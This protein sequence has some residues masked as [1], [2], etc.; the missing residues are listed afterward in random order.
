M[1][2]T[3]DM[4]TAFV[5]AVMN[6]V[7]KKDYDDL[8]RSAAT[9]AAL[10]ALPRA[11]ASIY[12]K[13]DTRQFVRMHHIYL[14]IENP[15][16][17]YIQDLSVAVP[18]GDVTGALIRTACADLLTEAGAQHQTREDLRLSLQVAA[19]RCTTTEELTKVFPEFARYVPKDPALATRNLPALANVVESFKKAGWSA[20]KKAVAA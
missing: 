6:D 1:R 8:I 16:G 20:N 2:L 12:K 5:N 15:S 19:D 17:A 11:V 4:R 13:E 7:P 9:A 3:K 18:G 10:D 14:R